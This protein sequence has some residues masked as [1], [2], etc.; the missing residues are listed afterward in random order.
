MLAP[1]EDALKDAI[2]LLD[3][4]I[5]ADVTIGAG[6]ERRLHVVFVITHPGEYNDWDLS[7]NV[8]NERGKR[9]PINFGHFEVD[10]DDFAVVVSEPGGSLES[11]GEGFGGVAV[12]AEISYQESS[13]A[14]V[15]VDDEELAGRSRREVHAV[16]Y[17][18][19]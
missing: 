4:K 3:R 12:L 16:L 1:G 2:E 15:I 18:P 5:L 7:I 9:D 10:D 13:D 19:Y 6:A 8:A 17:F 11:V 14:G